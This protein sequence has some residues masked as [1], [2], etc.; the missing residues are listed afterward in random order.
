MLR[1]EDLLSMSCAAE[2]SKDGEDWDL[3]NR[4]GKLIEETADSP[5]DSSDS[6]GL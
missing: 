2:R 4:F 1:E 5:S 3:D 6:S